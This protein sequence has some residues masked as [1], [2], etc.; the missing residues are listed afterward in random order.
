MNFKIIDPMLLL[1]FVCLLVV[2]FLIQ[3]P[4]VNAISAQMLINALFLNQRR[5]NETICFQ[6]SL[7]RNAIH[8]RIQHIVLK[9]NDMRFKTPTN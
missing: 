2:V 9:W 5:L 3:K 8:V 7:L 1:L 6:K 4:N